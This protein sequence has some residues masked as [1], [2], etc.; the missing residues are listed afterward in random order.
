[1]KEKKK[2]S[3]SLS[4]L[5]FY[6]LPLRFLLYSEKKNRERNHKEEKKGKIKRVV[7]GEIFSQVRVKK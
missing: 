5:L 7:R 6:V 3:F 4:T 1:M 2:N